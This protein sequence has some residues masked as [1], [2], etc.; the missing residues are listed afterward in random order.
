MLYNAAVQQEVLRGLSVTLGYYH[1]R[2]HD[3]FWT[4]NLATTHGDYSIIPIVDPR[5]NGQTVDVYSLNRAKF[6]LVNQFVT[7][8]NENSRTYHGL[9]LSF[10]ARLGIGA[11]LQG[12]VNSGKTRISDCQTD[13]PNNLRFCDR[14]Y[15]FRTQFKLSGSV[16]LPYRFRM[17]GVFSSLPGQLS[18]R[19]GDFTGLDLPITYTVT[20][21]IA[22]G[23][24][25]PSVNLLL[26][27]PDEYTLNRSNQLDIAF[28]RDFTVSGVRLR[29]QVDFFNA[30]NTNAVIRAITAYGP[31]LLS[32]REIL[33][34]RLIRLNLR[35]DF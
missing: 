6:G 1:R 13:D 22:A 9:D 35:M 24:T 26:S 7:N 2:Y 8:S 16:P 28:A 14:S 4:D 33:A 21:A 11:Q 25:Q 10:M 20:P 17:S 12:G 27:A 29:P 5:G 15:G 31:A 32:P 18:D 30:L 34:A 23:L 3:M 19:E